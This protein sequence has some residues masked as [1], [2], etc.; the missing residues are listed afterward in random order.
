MNS[1]IL[2]ALVIL[3]LAVTSG[4][5]IAQDDDTTTLSLSTTLPDCYTEELG[6]SSALY[7][8]TFHEELGSLRLDFTYNIIRFLADMT[9]P[10][11]LVDGYIEVREAN[12]DLIPDGVPCLQS[13]LLQQASERLLNDFFVFYMLAYMRNSDGCRHDAGRDYRL[14]MGGET[15]RPLLRWRRHLDPRT[16]S[17]SGEINP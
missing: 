4:V 3:M 13:F 10:E 6:E 1:K 16:R 15:S 17:R 2:R 5:S 12:I 9:T 7:I 11:E 8:Q 14:P